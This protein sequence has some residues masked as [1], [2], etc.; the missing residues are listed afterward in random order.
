[1]INLSGRG[2]KD[3]DSYWELKQMTGINKSFNEKNEYAWQ[4]SLTFIAALIFYCYEFYLRLLT[5]AYETN[6]VQHLHIN[7][8]LG[9]SFLISSYNYLCII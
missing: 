8:H 5:G 3:L 4:A 1:M 2:N 7:S 9:F 6:I